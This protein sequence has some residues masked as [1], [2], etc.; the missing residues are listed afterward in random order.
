MIVLKEYADTVTVVQLIN[1]KKSYQTAAQNALDV[2]QKCDT[3]NSL[4]NAISQFS[5]DMTIL[6]EVSKALGYGSKFVFEHP[7]T[8]LYT[9]ELYKLTNFDQARFPHIFG[10][11]EDRGHDPVYLQMLRNTCEQIIAD[12]GGYVKP[13]GKPDT[14]NIVFV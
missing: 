11:K 7:V 5:I 3:P 9:W 12:T 13:Y 8:A 6:C 10:S 1:L 4:R 2:G 14:E